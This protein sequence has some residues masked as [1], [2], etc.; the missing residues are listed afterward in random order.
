MAPT[1]SFLWNIVWWGG[2]IIEPSGKAQV[3]G[4]NYLLGFEQHRSA[5]Y[6]RIRPMTERISKVTR[7]T[8]TRLGPATI[9]IAVAAIGL[10]SLLLVDHGPW[11]KPSVQAGTMLE[12]GTTAG[13]A[14]AVG[15]V[16]TDTTTKSALEPAAPGPK[17]V[18]PA[19]PDQRKN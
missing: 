19:I 8:P 15:A 11:S 10:L 16:V 12:Y 9:A 3:A 7:A 4:R 13:A 1:G 6:L 14:A 2:L 18:S 5:T 17:P